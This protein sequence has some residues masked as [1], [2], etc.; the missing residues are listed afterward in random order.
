[1][2]GSPGGSPRCPLGGRALRGWP[3]P[4]KC[5]T[6]QPDSQSM[7]CPVLR[8]CLGDPIAATPLGISRVWTGSLRGASLLAGPMSSLVEASTS[9]TGRVDAAVADGGLVCLGSSCVLHR[10]R[11]VEM[12]GWKT[13]RHLGYAEDS[14]SLPGAF[15]AT[16]WAHP[17][18]ESQK[19]SLCPCH[20]SWPVRREP[21]HILSGTGDG[22]FPFEAVQTQPSASQRGY[23]VQSDDPTHTGL[24]PR[25]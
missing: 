25:D 16:A 11:V 18:N 24:K 10:R 12:G 15:S 4:R 7:G 21:V 19:T 3:T 13:A 20:V 2:W 9:P 1:M 14:P 6:P 23:F 17:S 8:S 5:R 22:P